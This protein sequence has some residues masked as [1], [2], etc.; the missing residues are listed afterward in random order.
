MHQREQKKKCCQK[1]IKLKIN[2][3][4]GWAA[5]SHENQLAP[6]RA[7]VTRWLKNT[8]INVR[9]SRW[10][11][12]RASNQ[13]SIHCA[14]D[15]LYQHQ[16]VR[17][18]SC[19]F[20]CWSRLCR[21][22]KT[23]YNCNRLKID[24][25]RKIYT[26]KERE[27]RFCFISFGL[28]AERPAFILISKYRLQHTHTRVTTVKNWCPSRRSHLAVRPDPWGTRQSWTDPCRIGWVGWGGRPGCAPLAVAT[29]NRRTNWK[30]IRETEKRMKLNPGLSGRWWMLL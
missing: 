28:Y 9:K 14:A 5:A 25:K 6:G 11:R 4:S 27:V 18:F 15:G 21:E 13:D 23:T 12:R 7:H 22:E 24:K 3:H 19:F 8:Q 1:W 26:L 10:N 29:R 30:K 2:P 16:L 20:L 17:N